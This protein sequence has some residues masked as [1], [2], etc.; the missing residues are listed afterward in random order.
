MAKKKKKKKANPESA[1]RNKKIAMI[2]AIVLGSAAVFVSAGMGIKAIDERAAE[3]IAPEKLTVHIAWGTDHDGHLWLPL[4]ERERIQRK[5]KAAITGSTALSWHPLHNASRALAS[6]GWVN[7]EPVARWNDDGSI[8]VNANWRLPAAA[9][10]V[11]DRDYIIDY[12]TN[13]LPLSYPADQ[14]NQFV[15]HNPALPNP[16]T[17]NPWNEP[18]IRDAL[19]LLIE[20]QSNDL[21]AQ[22]TGVD[23]GT[24]REH[25]ILQLLT[26]GGARII[27][28]GGPGRDRPAE[29]PSS[30]KMERLIS[31]YNKTGRI[32]AA[33]Q[34]VD[35]RG[36]H[37]LMQRHEN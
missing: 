30:V 22:I 25:G 23:L 18:E 14:S 15:I 3:F 29:M 2:S 1:D 9:V 12:D 17:G 6:T 10:R 34:I 8:T 26:N 33:V 20:L 7:N 35:I 21:H 28:G 36:Q 11:G 13:V 24:N 4:Q 19:A 32:D 27:W 37:I 5:V 31:L 16:G